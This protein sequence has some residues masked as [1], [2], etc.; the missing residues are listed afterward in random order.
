MLFIYAVVGVQLF[1]NV[2]Y[3]DYI[4]P[5]ANFENT[6][7]AMMLLFRVTT[8]E[9]WNSLM[10]E[11]SVEPP[12]CTASATMNDCGTYVGARLFFYS[13][14]VIGTYV[15]INLF[16]AVLVEAFPI[17]V[18]AEASKIPKQAMQNYRDRWLD[19]NGDA[20]YMPLWKMRA[21]VQSLDP[22]VGFDTYA[23]RQT[24]RML[25]YEARKSRCKEKNCVAFR[26][27]LQ[28][29][30]LHRLGLDCLKLGDRIAREHRLSM[31]VRHLAV[32]T[33][34]SVFH[35]RRVRNE[36]LAKKQ[37]MRAEALAEQLMAIN[38]VLI[39]SWL[40]FTTSGVCGQ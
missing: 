32:E 4:G 11:C 29:L 19:F 35:M 6:G 7:Y 5:I 13:F 10:Y 39:L 23:N 8:G 20:K 26:T 30:A 3:G 12:Y 15:F 9:D 36:Y 18:T 24:W 14:Y 1:G 21:F 27:L 28:L 33:I 40:N 25:H 31:I 38:E 37:Q 34:R 2:R 17:A 22:S 16:V